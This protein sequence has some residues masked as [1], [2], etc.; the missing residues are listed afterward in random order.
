[1]VML[2]SIDAQATQIC[3]AN[4]SSIIVQT[5]QE[6]GNFDASYIIVHEL[7]L[8]HSYYFFIFGNNLKMNG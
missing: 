5:S 1:M 4:I 7:H 2:Q 8:L 3:T 6:T